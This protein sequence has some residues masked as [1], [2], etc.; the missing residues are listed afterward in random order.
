MS[1]VAICSDLNTF[2]IHCY[3]LCNSSIAIHPIGCA[4]IATA[5]SW[6]WLFICIAGHCIT[7]KKRNKS[8][9]DFVFLITYLVLQITIACSQ[10]RCI[11]LVSLL[12]GWF[13]GTFNSNRE[14]L[15][16]PLK[17]LFVCSST[18]LEYKIMVYCFFSNWLHARN[19]LQ[20]D[21]W[22]DC[23]GY[24]DGSTQYSNESGEYTMENTRS[25]VRNSRWQSI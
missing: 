12:A 4:I 14:L 6:Y 13:F 19:S 7:I 9:N 11:I 18:R 5:V 3:S 8:P 1:K 25:K 23:C 24:F 2:N 10:S 16:L 21:F 22:C 17:C 20:I 15:W